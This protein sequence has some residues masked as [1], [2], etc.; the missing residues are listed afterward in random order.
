LFLRKPMVGGVDILGRRLRREFTLNTKPDENARL[1]LRG[2]LGHALVCLDDRLL[3]LKR[4]FHAGTTFG[5][6]AATIFYRDVT[7]IQVR[8][9]LVSGWIEISSPSF[10]GNE[11]KK[12]GRPRS[13]DRDVFK[14]PNC[15]PIQRRHVRVYQVALTEL[16]RLVAE[17]K[18]EHDHGGVVDQLER[19]AALRRQGVV[20]EVEFASAKSRIIG[21]ASDSTTDL[22]RPA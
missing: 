17:A 12:L 16:R 6:M 22:A 21:G 8:M 7:G 14:Q 1:C 4:G 5:A 3:I 10:Q 15:V 13:A 20:D 9:H 11:R 18:Q 2:E 19:L